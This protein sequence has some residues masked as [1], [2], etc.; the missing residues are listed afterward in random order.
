MGYRYNRG[1][2]DKVLRGPKNDSRAIDEAVKFVE[3]SVTSWGGKTTFRAVLKATKEYLDSKNLPATRLGDWA[4]L[5]GDSQTMA[6]L[7]SSAKKQLSKQLLD[8]MED[9]ELSILAI[10]QDGKPTI[11]YRTG[12]V[13]ITLLGT[14]NSRSWARGTR[15]VRMAKDGTV[16]RMEDIAA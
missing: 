1:L 8:E 3:E 14:S 12:R 15:V 2:E 16:L 5:A 11:I 13:V 6:E 4:L 10:V 7:A 9:K